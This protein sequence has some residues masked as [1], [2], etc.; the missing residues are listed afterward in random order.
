VGHQV[1]LVGL[2]FYQR[3]QLGVELQGVHVAQGSVAQLGFG[4]RSHFFTKSLSA[5]AMGEM[6][7]P[8]RRPWCS[9]TLASR[10]LE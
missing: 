9:I 10:R 3:A 2:L 6:L 5:P 1:A 4:Q 8:C 7:Q